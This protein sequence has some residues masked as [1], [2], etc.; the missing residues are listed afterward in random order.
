MGGGVPTA[1]LLSER[2]SS[3]QPHPASFAASKGGQPQFGAGLTAIAT[4]GN[5]TKVIVIRV[6]STLAGVKHG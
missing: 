1:L 2:P 4:V 5:G 6:Q 3:E